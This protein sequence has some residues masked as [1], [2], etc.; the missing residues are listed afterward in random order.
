MSTLPQTYED[1]LQRICR[2]GI[3]PAATATDRDHAFPHQAMEALKTGGF[4][5]AMSSPEVG[6]LGLGLRGAA[7]IV[8]SV[9]EQCGST[10][11]VL[12]MH[13]SGVA[14]L[15]AYAPTD[16]RR[17]AAAGDHLST[18][19]FSEAGSLQPLLGA[20]EY[21][22]GAERRRRAERQQELGHFRVTRN[23]VRLV[24]AAT[25]R[26]RLQ[27]YL[28]RSGERSRTRRSGAV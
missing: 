15:E 8:R 24:F 19:A 12:C 5:G 27:H 21:G 9:A 6:G 10:A 3:A 18:L 17:A 28:A 23:G 22:H 20:P 7:N 14:V 13:Y 11:M 25:R 1:S 4:L 26:Q 16:V 2:D